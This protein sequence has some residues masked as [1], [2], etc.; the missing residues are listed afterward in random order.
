M[1]SANADAATQ[2]LRRANA[3]IEKEDGA[4]A[5]RMVDKARRLYPQHEDLERVA[6]AAA[7][8]PQ[9]AQPPPTP[10]ST[11]IPRERPSGEGGSAGRQGG[12]STPNGGGGEGGERR[13][14]GG[15]PTST[16]SRSS[17]QSNG[18]AASSPS[19]RSHH[20]PTEA[21]KDTANQCIAAAHAAAAAGDA[22]KAQR[23]IEKAKRL[24]PQHP[25][26]G[27]AMGAAAQAARGGTTPGGPTARQRASSSPASSD[28]GFERK[29]TPQEIAAV[30]RI[31]GKTDH[32]EVLDVPKTSTDAE[33]KKA[34]RKLALKLHPDKNKAKGADDAFKAVSKAFAVLSDGDKRASYDRFGMDDEQ[35]QAAR[36][37]GRG[38]R[39]GGGFHG[40]IDPEEIFRQF[41]GGNFGGGQ[42]PRA[43]V[44]RQQFGG[45]RRQHQHQHQRQRQTQ[46]DDQ[47]N[48]N[49]LQQTLFQFL[50]LL[51]M[52]IMSIFGGDGN[53]SVYS[54]QQT[55]SYP[56]AVRT[57]TE[58][59]VP[60]YVK[61][62]AQVNGCC[63]SM[64]LSRHSR[65]FLVVS[66][67]TLTLSCPV[68]SSP[69]FHS[70]S[71]RILA[72]RKSDR[73]WRDR[74]RQSTRRHWST[75]VT[76]SRSI[77]RE[78]DGTDRERT[79]TNHSHPCHTVKS[80][81]RN[82]PAAVEHDRERRLA[83]TRQTRQ[84][85]IENKKGAF[86]FCICK[87]VTQDSVCSQR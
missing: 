59:D 24:Y 62:M 32:Y 6:A 35:L 78:T 81:T 12:A 18:H 51:I 29:G 86:L 17:H 50:P 11:D 2:C 30:R 80:W 74:S 39:G 84:T 13:Q 79:P 14:G 20:V 36:A 37:S 49:Q 65:G 68:K 48:R 71:R 53:S 8:C 40:D 10:E 63:A 52:A 31:L 26:I 85:I 82:F 72:C 38:P 27:A 45:N 7:A 19:E 22:S 44:F 3:A 77:S 15:A 54:L 87:S 41:F 69:L 66:P 76:T 56:V 58:P 34:Y 70:L 5:T 47:Q 46:G 55:S 60:F 16:P 57:R 1:S 21:N 43:R 4:T 9:T 73:I 42:D 61:N 28:S 64:P 83:T 67:P 23:M 75:D 33:I 25:G